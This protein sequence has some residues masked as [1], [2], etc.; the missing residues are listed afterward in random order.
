MCDYLTFYVIPWP[1]IKYFFIFW[2][3][4]LVLIFRLMIIIFFIDIFFD[5]LTCNWLDTLF[6]N[7]IF[8]FLFK[9]VLLL[10]SLL[11]LFLLFNHLLMLLLLLKQ[12]LFELFNFKEFLIC[13]EHELPTVV[14]ESLLLLVFTIK[15]IDFIVIVETH[16]ADHATKLNENVILD[17]KV[18]YLVFLCLQHYV[19]VLVYY[20]NIIITFYAF[21]YLLNFSVIVLILEP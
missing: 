16:Q 9:F 5:L 18:V 20:Q 12:D 6:T 8:D 4:I 10:F 15:L 11:F 2:F 19:D 3:L 1:I 7:F 13:V 21:K 17:Y 14:F